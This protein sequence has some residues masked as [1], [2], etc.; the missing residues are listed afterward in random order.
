MLLV[1]GQDVTAASAPAATVPPG[2]Q[3]LTS[4]SLTAELAVEAALAAIRECRKLDQGVGVVVMSPSGLQLAMIRGD[5]ARLH[6]VEGAAYKAYGAASYGMNG[7]EAMAMREAV[8]LAA[9][10][11]RVA[12]KIPNII[13]SESG[14]VFKVGN[15]VIGAIGVSGARGAG[16]DLQCAKAGVD[17]VAARLK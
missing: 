7:E 4:H 12:D 10:R 8:P 14:R 2:E 13:V 5:G 3:L 11:V 16:E 17:A 6:A 15:E 9:G 1:S